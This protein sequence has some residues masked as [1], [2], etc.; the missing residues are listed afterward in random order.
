MERNR[1][2]QILC[3]GP[4]CN[5]GQSAAARE[6]IPQRAT[7]NA[8]A[9]AEAEKSRRNETSRALKLTP[10][11]FTRY[12]DHGALMFGCDDCGHERVYGNTLH[13]SY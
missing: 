3:E 13:T 8:V 9:L 11:V 12:G 1:R 5:G 7:M 4:A 2:V 6:T 10:H